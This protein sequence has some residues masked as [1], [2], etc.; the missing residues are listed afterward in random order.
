M[1]EGRNG[2]G[3]NSPRRMGEEEERKS[4]K[5]IWFRAESGG[6]GVFLTLRN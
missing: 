1:L 5:I 3:E 6:S 4:N 2:R